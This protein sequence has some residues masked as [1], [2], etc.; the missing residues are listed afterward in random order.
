MPQTD[1]QISKYTS[2]IAMCHGIQQTKYFK[3][4]LPFEWECLCTKQADK[5]PENLQDTEVRIKRN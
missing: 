3:Q 1:I 5:I 2:W 4:I